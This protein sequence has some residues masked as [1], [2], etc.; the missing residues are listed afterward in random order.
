MCSHVTISCLFLLITHNIKN[1]PSKHFYQLFDILFQLYNIILTVCVNGR[2]SGGFFMMYLGM[3]LQLTDEA[4][5]G[6]A[7]FGNTCVPDVFDQRA[8]LIRFRDVVRRTAERHINLHVRYRVPHTET[9]REHVKHVN[10]N[11]I[12]MGIIHI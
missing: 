8:D 3:R 11:T 7:E 9:I 10:L 12:R 1:F 2:L 4:V 5:G 6:E